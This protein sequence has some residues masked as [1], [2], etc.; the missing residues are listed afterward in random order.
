LAG[1]ASVQPITA[2][3]AE[4]SLA[5]GPQ[6]AIFEAAMFVAAFAALGR[7][8]GARPSTD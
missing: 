7:P 3:H 5:V 2:E 8:V 1:T 4:R 6:R